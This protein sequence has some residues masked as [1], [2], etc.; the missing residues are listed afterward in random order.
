LDDLE[1]GSLYKKESAEFAGPDLPDIPEASGSGGQSTVWVNEAEKA[2]LDASKSRSG[3]RP[4]WSIESRIQR[5]GNL[6]PRSG[7][8]STQA[9]RRDQSLERGQLPIEAPERSATGGVARG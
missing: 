1:A 4:R 7:M 2:M 9:V 6:H 5:P 3:S 8:V